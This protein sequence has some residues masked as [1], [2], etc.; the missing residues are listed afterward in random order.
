MVVEEDGT[1]VGYALAALNVK[2]FNQK[3]A[4]SW[5]PELQAKYP[6]DDSINSLPQDAKVTFHSSI[7]CGMAHGSHV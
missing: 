6:L 3:M 7:N 4:V 5:I 2:T 1:I